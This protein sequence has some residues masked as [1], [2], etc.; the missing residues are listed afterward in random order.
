MFT[1]WIPSAAGYNSVESFSIVVQCS[2]IHN[3]RF[4]NLAA[5]FTCDFLI[6]YL[7][8][9]HFYRS[10]HT[11]NWCTGN[12]FSTLLF[13]LLLLLNP[14]HIHLKY[15]SLP[16]IPFSSSSRTQN[17][18][19]TS[20]SLSI[21]QA[22]SPKLIPSSHLHP[23]KL[24]KVLLKSAISAQPDP[25]M[26]KGES[27]TCPWSVVVGGKIGIVASASTVPSHASRSKPGRTH[28]VTMGIVL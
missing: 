12:F 10:V 1:I 20:L 4:G 13:L 21:Y 24:P 11:Y 25:H 2:V 7:Q 8:S 5:K 17:R 28:K 3:L 16:R 26:M 23:N 15:T 18:T 14:R 19:P 22:R 27:Q 9:G 6:S